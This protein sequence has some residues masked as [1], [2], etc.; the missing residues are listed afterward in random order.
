MHRLTLC[1][2]REPALLWEKFPAPGVERR[3]ATACDVVL[4]RDQAAT[5]ECRWHPWYRPAGKHNR[6]STTVMHNRFRFSLQWLDDLSF[7]ST[8]A[9]LAY[10]TTA[11]PHRPCPRVVDI[12]DVNGL[13][14]LFY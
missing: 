13:I 3:R 9:M 14:A 4:Y 2:R 6:R 11:R 1:A 5:Q 7:E 8:A 10:R 12:T